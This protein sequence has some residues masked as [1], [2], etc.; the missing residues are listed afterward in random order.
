M[1]DYERKT[2]N[3]V[4]RATVSKR[5][6]DSIPTAS[7][8]AEKE[9]RKQKNIERIKKFGAINPQSAKII[10]EGVN[11][12]LG[13]VLYE[14]YKYTGYFERNLYEKGFFE[15]GTRA[16]FA[17][18]DKLSPEMIKK[19]AINDY[20]SGVYDKDRNWEEMEL[21]MIVSAITNNPFYQK[22]LV[23]GMVYGGSQEESNKKTR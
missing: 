15:N 9:L 5:N 22:G 11:D 14:P 8:S 4:T 19:I 10:E 23:I 21:S 6:S 12:R 16:L 2:Y 20:L 13:A 3:G 18:L 17:R 1:I 7:L